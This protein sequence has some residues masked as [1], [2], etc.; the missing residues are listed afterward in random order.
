MFF[1][2]ILP[3]FITSHF[4]NTVIC[5]AEVL[6]CSEVQ[7]YQFF[8]LHELSCVASKKSCQGFPGGSEVKNL[9]ADG[10]DMSSIPGLRGSHL[11]RRD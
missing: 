11:P 1:A 8:F 6:N 9:P 7:F 4:L 10:G 2:Y 5:R 3:Q